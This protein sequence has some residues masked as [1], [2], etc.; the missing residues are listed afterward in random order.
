VQPVRVPRGAPHDRAVLAG[1]WLEWP[2]SGRG[3]AD[4]VVI[5]TPAPA[6]QAV[7]TRRIACDPSCKCCQFLCRFHLVES[8]YFTPGRRVLVANPCLGITASSTRMSPLGVGFH[9]SC[10]EEMVYLFGSHFYKLIG[11]SLFRL[12]ILSLTRLGS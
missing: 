11:L 7:Q 6:I 9:T 10:N 1:A 4:D 3:P 2:A 5:W 8:A 12:D